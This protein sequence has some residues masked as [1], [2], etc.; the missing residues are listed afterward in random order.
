MKKI[1][2]C[3]ILLLFILPAVSQDKKEPAKEPEK[4]AGEVEQVTQSIY[5]EIAL[6]DFETSQYSNTNIKFIQAKEQQG[7]I[8]IRDQY[9]AEFN[10]SK[11]YLGVKLYA[12]KGDTF[13]IFPAKPIEITKYCKSISVWV[14]GKKF[15]GEFSMM[16]Q[17]V[18]GT[19]HRVSFG[20]TAF[21]GW[22]KLTVNLDPKIKQQDAYLEKEK[23]LKIL[24]IQY[25]ASNDSLHPEWQYFYI[26][27]ITATVRD[28]Y[29]D[30]QSD[31]W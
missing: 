18:N 5:T 11:K 2:I 4:K 27:D 19:T 10:N 29:K 15:S 12:K 8:A 17:D 6:E 14:Y 26:D 28:K 30:R 20:N 24:H 23:A 7:S 16:L 9:P 31:D 22:K 21:L 3:F 25:R 1:F 13:Q